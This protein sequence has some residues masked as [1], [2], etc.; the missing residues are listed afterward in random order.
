MIDRDNIA[1]MVNISIISIVRFPDKSI[2]SMKL[3][4]KV[5]TARKSVYKAV[6]REYTL[7]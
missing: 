7:N 3:K 6:V 5:I 4:C 1:V 2:L